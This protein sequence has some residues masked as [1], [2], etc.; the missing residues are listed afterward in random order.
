MTNIVGAIAESAKTPQ[1]RETIRERGGLKP[2]IKLIASTSPGIGVHKSKLDSSL[3]LN[4]LL[5]LL[6]VRYIR[7]TQELD[8]LRT[9]IKL[10]ASTML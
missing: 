2:V 7:S 9:V 1:N 3:L 10:I 8:G 4:S 5:Q 6:K